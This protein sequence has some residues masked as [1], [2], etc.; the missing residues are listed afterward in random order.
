MKRRVAPINW[1]TSISSFC[2]SIC[3]RMV[4]P[5]TNTTAAASRVPN[6]KTMCSA[7]AAKRFSFCA[8]AK[9]IATIS[10]FG[11]AAISFCSAASASE[12]LAL[13]R[14]ENACGNGL[15]SRLESR[16]DKFSTRFISVSAVS[17]EMNVTTST[18][19]SNFNFRSTSLASCSLALSAR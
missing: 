12:S 15:V 13:G 14:M 19:A 7:K 9:S 3:R 18:F 1:L 8:H 11:S 2:V 4:L 5:V 16:S 10:I 17:R 6:S